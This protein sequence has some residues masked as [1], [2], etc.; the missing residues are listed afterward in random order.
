MT[1]VADYIIIG[2][3]IAGLYTAWK[4]EHKHP[5]STILILE[6]NKHLG[7]RLPMADFMGHHI[8]RGA[9]IGRFP[10]DRLLMRLMKKLHMDV[11]VVTSTMDTVPKIPCKVDKIVEELKLKQYNRHNDDFETFYTKNR[12]DLK[13]FNQCVGFTDFLKADIEDTLY[14]YGF[15]DVSPT[16][17][18]IPINWD[19][20]I[21]RLYSQLKNTRVLLDCRVCAVDPYEKDCI[22]SRGDVYMFKKAVIFATTISGLNSLQNMS[23]F[24]YKQVSNIH[25]Q[26]FIRSYAKIEPPLHLPHGIKT[27]NV[28]QKVIPI[29]DK[30]GIYMIA[31]ADNKNALAIH[32]NPQII[33][34]LVTPHKIVKL[35][36]FFHHE[37]THYFEPLP[38]NWR[39]RTGYLKYIQHPH[40]NVYIVGEMVS[41]N[42]GWTEGALD[43]VHKIL[44]FI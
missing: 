44:R 37:G 5:K 10:K 11:K 41:R 32:E 4:L 43:S 18:I 39:S 25:S 38:K 31:Y 3:G 24:F 13:N 1:I 34:E 36:S 42:Q 40:K 29:D 14:D 19:V 15:D 20:M 17:R 6:K 33:H 8:T 23:P 16:T 28:L 30:E 35:K 7:G 2:G 22:D 27:N 9:G 12:N 26:P 21:D